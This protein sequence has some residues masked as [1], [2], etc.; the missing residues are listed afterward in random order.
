[1]G[2]VSV[3]ARKYDNNDRY[4]EQIQE[5]LWFTQLLNTWA[6]KTVGSSSPVQKHAFHTSSQFNIYTVPP[7]QTENSPSLTKDLHWWVPCSKP[8]F[9]KW[10]K[11]GFKPGFCWHVLFNSTVEP[12]RGTLRRN[13]YSTFLLKHMTRTLITRTLRPHISVQFDW[14]ILDTNIFCCLLLCYV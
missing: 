2:G 5:M 9:P 1:M 6:H 3:W 14:F 12:V 10:T 7:I 8:H 4:T 13:F 11:V